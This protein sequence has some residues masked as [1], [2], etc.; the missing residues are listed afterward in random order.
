MPRPLLRAGYRL[1]YFVLST[2][3]WVLGRAPGGVKCV[4][5]RG[6]EVLLV[7]HTYGP[8]RWELPGGGRHRGEEPAAAARRETRE[9]LG[10]DVPE[11][12]TLGALETSVGRANATLYPFLARVEDLDPVRDDVEIA[13]ARFFRLDALPTPVGD[14]V[15]RILE[16]VPT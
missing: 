1:A 9:E 12:T 14:D 13:E 5:L 2:T 16:R 7:R 4:I 6:D 3:W 8:N 15:P 10:A 11:W